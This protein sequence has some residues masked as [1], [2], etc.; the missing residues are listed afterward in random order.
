MRTLGSK[1]NLASSIPTN[2]R[3]R[4]VDK[5]EAEISVSQQAKLLEISRSSIYYRACLPDPQDVV[6]KHAIDQIFTEYP[7]YGSRRIHVD[8]AIRHGLV[9]N[10]K[11]IQRHMREMGIVAIFPGPNL[12]RRAHQ[13]A[14]FPYLLRG[15]KAQVC[16]DV[17]GIDITYI[18][19]Q[20]TWMYLVAIIDWYTR[21]I[22]AWE[23]DDTLEMPFVLST[24][25]R[26]LSIGKPVIFNS[27]QGSHFT[28]PQYIEPLQ[29]AKIRISMDGKGRALDNI[30]I[31]RFWRTIKYEEVY[32]NE[33]TSPK[34]ARVRIRAFIEFYNQTRPHQSLGYRSPATLYHQ[35]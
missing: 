19:L 6:I 31:E 30:Y 35:Q 15:Y 13:H 12:S 14:V 22:V 18:R 33:Y 29:K 17:W 24:V 32:L 3:R 16:N 11:A 1:K 34:E 2:E 5:N 10:R 27:D 8:L 4:L 23:L 7:F 25:Q 21:F 9:V 28:S 20:R 26:A